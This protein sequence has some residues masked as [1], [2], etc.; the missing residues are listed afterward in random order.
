[1]RASQSKTLELLLFIVS[2]ITLCLP[3]IINGYPVVNPDSGTYI[4]SG[5]I[6]EVPADRPITYGILTRLFSINGLS[7]WGAVIMQA[8]LI[9]YI[10]R[11]CIK[12]TVV[13]SSKI[14]TSIIA[15]LLALFSTISW[16]TS[17]LIADV[18]TPIMLLSIACILST[19][20]SQ[21]KMPVLL[22]IVFFVT[23]ATHASHLSVSLCILLLIWLFRKLLFDESTIKKQ[24]RSLYIMTLL[25]ASTLAINASVFSKSSAAFMT[26]AMINKGVVTEYLQ[27]ICG[28][29]QY[30]MCKYKDDIT[31]DSDYFLWNTEGPLAKMGGW[32]EAREACN[33]INT[34]ILTTYPY[35]WHFA[36][37]SFKHTL[38]QAAKFNIGDGNEPLTDTNG[39]YKHIN[40]FV[41][42]T[43]AS[44]YIHSKQNNGKLSAII[45]S[46]NRVSI[47]TVLCSLAII[48]FVSIRYRKLISRYQFTFISIILVGICINFA[49][50][51]TFSLYNGRYGVKVIWLIPLCAMLLILS[52]IHNKKHSTSNA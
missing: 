34:G 17:E 39:I 22:Y 45:K 30:E 10:I 52:V 42:S 1:M 18:Y 49:Q 3:A 35:N 7:L 46:I 4:E 15:I 43:E 50:C 47:I 8:I 38:L 37:E 48:V 24:V 29:S 36:K 14:T 6:L 27:A 20:T 44:H 31:T 11:A 13:T 33:K 16:I 5:F 12:S 9:H 19:Q 25:S 21:Q 23:T 51:A 2:I 32:T 40:Q 28:N 41:S 26:A